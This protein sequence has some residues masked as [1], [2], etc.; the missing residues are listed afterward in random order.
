MTDPTEGPDQPVE[1]E[2]DHD[3][4]K[5]TAEEWAYVEALSASDD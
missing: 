5:L 1:T 2:D 4:P 3:T